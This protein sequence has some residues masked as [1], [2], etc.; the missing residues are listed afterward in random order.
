MCNCKTTLRNYLICYS[1]ICSWVLHSNG[2]H[3]AGL[4]DNI[5][6]IITVKGKSTIE[7]TLKRKIKKVLPKYARIKSI[8]IISCRTVPDNRFAIPEKIE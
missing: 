5:T 7:A 3:C 4:S 6:E 1:Y 8:E 2:L